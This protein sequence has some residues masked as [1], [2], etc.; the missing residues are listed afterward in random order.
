M[1]SAVYPYR[2]SMGR[3]EAYGRKMPIERS[4]AEHYHVPS[5]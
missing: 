1:D 4:A 2:G 5:Q 3:P